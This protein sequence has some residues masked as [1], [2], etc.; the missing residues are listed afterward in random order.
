M[1][2]QQTI[3]KE[4]I[5]SVRISNFLEAYLKRTKQILRIKAFV[6]RLKDM[7][8][9]TLQDLKDSK[10]SKYD[11]LRKEGIGTV[12]TNILYDALKYYGMDSVFFLGTKEKYPDDT[13]SLRVISSVFFDTT[14]LTS[15]QK[16]AVSRLINLMSS[17]G[18]KNFSDLQTHDIDFK[19]YRTDRQVG[20]VGIDLFKKMIKEYYQEEL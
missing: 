17:S 3:K 20:D 16:M 5:G 9:E 6:K 8:L 19:K 1:K 2:E 11:L 10:M 14:Q 18:I 15:P 7:G 13:T 4:E 12:R